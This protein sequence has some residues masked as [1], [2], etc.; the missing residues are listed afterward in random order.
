VKELLEAQENKVKLTVLFGEKNPIEV[1]I[2]EK[3][4]A[5]LYNIDLNRYEL[6]DIVLEEDDDEEEN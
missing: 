1:I 3:E 5:S 6:V 4:L 2:T